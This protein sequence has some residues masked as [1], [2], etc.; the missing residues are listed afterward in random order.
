MFLQIFCC[1]SHIIIKI[2]F[3][4]IYWTKNSIVSKKKRF[5]MV[6]NYNG[7]GMGR[8]RVMELPRSCYA[9]YFSDA[10]AILAEAKKLHIK[11]SA[12]EAHSFENAANMNFYSIRSYDGAP[13]VM[14]KV[15]D[16]AVQWCRGVYA[17]RPDNYMRQ[18][19]TFI[20]KKQFDIAHDMA[21]TG[22]VRQHGK[23]YNVY[24]LPNGFVFHGDMDLSYAGLRH[25]PDMRSVTIRGNYDISGNALRSFAGVPKE[26]YGDFYANDNEIP[27]MLKERPKFC[28]IHGK[29]YTGPSK[30]R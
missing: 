13:H 7:L 6:Q 10:D 3:F 20:V 27:Y 18:V 21:C 11:L 26:I 25:L 19:V 23:Y 2:F 12:E 8:H 1:L 9:V 30:S 4:L 17:A 24:D 22:I 14:L 28:A 15:V 29:F 5:A 16:D